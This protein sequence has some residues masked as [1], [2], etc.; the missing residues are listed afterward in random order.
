MKNYKAYVLYF[1]KM[2]TQFKKNL[3]RNLRFLIIIVLTIGVL[4][5]LINLDYK[6]YWGDETATLLRISGYTKTEIKQQINYNQLL[7]INDL[8]KYQTINSQKNA[9]DTILGLAQE[10]PQL[11]PL[12]FLIAR[13]AV[14]FFGNSLTIPRGVSAFLS[15]LI[16]PCI[17][18]LALELFSSIKV[19]WIAMAITAISPFHVLYAQEARPYSLWT[20]TILLSSATF[21]R[22]IKLNTKLSWGLYLISLILGLYSFLLSVL[23]IAAHGLYLLIINSFKFNKIFVNFII[24]CF[25][26]LVTYLPWIVLFLL[27]YESFQK[28]SNWALTRFPLSG[29]IN[30]WMRNISYS[31]MDFWYYFTYHPNSKLNLLYGKFLIPLLLIMIGFSFYTLIKKSSVEVWL[32]ILMLMTTNALAMAAPDVINGGYRSIM[33]KYFVPCYIGIQLSVAYLFAIKFDTLSQRNYKYKFWQLS[34]ILLI[35]GGIISC[36]ISSQQKVWWNKRN[37]AHDALLSAQ[38]I[39]Q[40]K[41]SVIVSKTGF[42]FVLG[43]LV[44]PETK[45]I[46]NNDNKFLDVMNNCQ[47]NYFF[48]SAKKPTMVE[49]N[50]Q[51]YKMQLIRKGRK[52]SLWQL[53]SS[54]CQNP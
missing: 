30:E 7:T 52:K 1:K 14:K 19:G 26:S 44:N 47:M 29:L 32:F 53:K 21:L 11:P 54:S 50:N 39:N 23:V 20:I 28:T 13:T 22:A 41:N 4:F 15:L 38:I 40:Q 45:F 10:E 6:V 37:T 25:L 31:F 46:I 17:Y 3:S 43:H 8:K 49:N 35:M 36:A 42:P 34:L 18:W 5:R 2:S 48:I 27:N 51:K 24:I 9:K 33:S 12:Y 16:F